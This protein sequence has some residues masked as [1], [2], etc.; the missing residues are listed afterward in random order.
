MPIKF[1][2]I[3]ALA[4]V[5]FCAGNCSVVNQ[6]KKQL[7]K[8]QTP[9][10]VAATDGK[11]SLTVPGNWRTLTTLHQEAKLKTADVGAEQYA[12]VIS[13]SKSG[14][15]EDMTFDD[16][17]ELVRQR[18]EETVTDLKVSEP[19]SLEIDGHPARQFEA[20]GAVDKIKIKWLF[21]TVDGPKNFHQIVMWTTAG[22]WEENKS[23]FLETAKSFRET[24]GKTTVVRETDK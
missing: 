19:V 2:K 4:A 6:F 20:S 13:E 14:F 18:P 16:F 7:T 23:V 10:I 8:T 17:N 5:L 1:L 11:C 21:T 22:K 9:K 24:E 3:F 12:I 15:T